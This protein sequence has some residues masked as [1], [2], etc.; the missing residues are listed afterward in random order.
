MAYVLRADVT[1]ASGHNAPTTLYEAS[2]VYLQ[3]DV[4][5]VKLK[6]K[7]VKYFIVLIKQRTRYF[8]LI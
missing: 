7:Q 6:L 5:E 3:H 4:F 1:S 8:I 2:L